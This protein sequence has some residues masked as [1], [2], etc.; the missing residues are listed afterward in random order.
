MAVL[1]PSTACIQHDILIH[2]ASLPVHLRLV[3][4]AENTLDCANHI[5]R[6]SNHD[7]CDDLLLCKSVHGRFIWA[8][9]W[10]FRSW[11]SHAVKIRIISSFPSLCTPAL[12]N[13]WRGM[14][15]DVAGILHTGYGTY[16]VALLAVRTIAAGK[17]EV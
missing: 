10:C 9:L 15:D 12:Q 16:T 8:S 4:T 5:P 17:D 11:S 14:G 2:I 7:H 6:S 1:R 13:T 3:D